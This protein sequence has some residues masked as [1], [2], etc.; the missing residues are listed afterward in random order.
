M[1][2]YRGA[3][4]GKSAPAGKPLR[5]INGD[6]LALRGERTVLGQMLRP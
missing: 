2:A 1:P 5:K 3:G 4:L 6:Y